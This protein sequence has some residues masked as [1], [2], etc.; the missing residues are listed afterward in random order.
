MYKL[1]ELALQ[2][3]N[4]G[5]NTALIHR[6]STHHLLLQSAI[7]II[8]LRIHGNRYIN[9]SIFRRRRV[10]SLASKTHHQ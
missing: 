1:D 9:D 5:I 8:L 6:P 7:N 2:P 4:D 10:E 3:A